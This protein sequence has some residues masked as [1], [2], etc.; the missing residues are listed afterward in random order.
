[1]QKRDPDAAPLLRL[2]EW[3]IDPDSLVAELEARAAN[4]FRF[5]D[6]ASTA[7]GSIYMT[8]AAHR[9]VLNDAYCLFSQTNPLH[10]AQFPSIRR[11]EAE[12]IAM[13]A[14]LVGGGPD[15]NPEVRRLCRYFCWYL[16]VL[17]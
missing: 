7:T 10:P 3:G 13:T 5:A 11:M 4:D 1:M 16:S 14:S 8:G 6:G 2:P 17:S 15:G 9:D 12:V